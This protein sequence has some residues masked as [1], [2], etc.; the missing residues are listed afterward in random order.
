MVILMKK[1]L[2]IIV[3]T[4]LVIIS[5]LY[6]YPVIKNNSYE[7]K[8]LKNI[9]DNTDI[10]NISY[11]NKNNNYYILKTDL[12][13]IVLNLNYEEI[14]KDKLTSLYASDLDLVYRRNKLFYVEKKVNGKKLTYNYYD[15]YTYELIYETNIGGE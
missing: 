5:F 13:V 15:A 14:F 6:T 8:L 7:K 11:L 1:V 12:E 9:Y 10:E 2:V 4:I 3:I